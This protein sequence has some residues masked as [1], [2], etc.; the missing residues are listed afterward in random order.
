MTK[1]LVKNVTGPQ[2]P[3]G[4]AGAAGATGPQGPQGPAG[5]SFV[6]PRVF[7]PAD[8]GAVFDAKIATDVSV[9]ATQVIT[10]A[11]IAANAAVGMW[12]MINGAR[13]SGDTC[14]IGQITNISGGNITL[15]STPLPIS[16]S[17]TALRAVYGTDDT[18]GI[19][20]A[21]AAAKTYG[22][23]H[24]M[25][26]VVDIGDRK[27]IVATNNQSDDGTALYNTSVKI[28]FPSANNSSK[29][30][31]VLRGIVRTDHLEYWNATRTSQIGGTIYALLTAPST[32]DAT[33]GPQSVIGA[34]VPSSS[35]GMNGVISPTFVNI[36]PIVENLMIVLPTYSNLTAFDFRY[37]TGLYMDGCSVRAFSDPLEGTGTHLTD[38]F[39]DPI[40]GSRLG[41]GLRI[42]VGGNNADVYIPSFATEGV[43]M[44]LRTP[45]EHIRINRLICIYTA[46]ILGIDQ[47]ATS[48]GLSIG[49][50]TAEA[51]QGGIRVL[52][53]G[54]GATFLNIESWSTENSASVS[55]G[56]GYDIYDPGN[57]LHGQ[58]FFYDNTDAR[59]PILS[60]DAKNFRVI[61]A[62]KLPWNGEAQTPVLVT[63][64]DG[65]TINTNAAQGN[66]FRVTLGGNRTMAAPTNPADGQ[67]I[68]YEIVQDGTGSRTLTWDAAFSFGGGVAPVLTTTAGG[69]DLVGFRYSS[70]KSKWLSLGFSTGF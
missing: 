54:S 31:P 36:K 46:V 17:A 13:G 69:V 41:V 56:G 64:T 10:S 16:V 40:F 9:N 3:A 70:T 28:P 8:Y 6:D 15:G 37:A 4:A 1:I 62:R 48:H 18:T 55:G 52:D 67:T 66:E 34:P 44:A 57:A 12:V 26:C 5:S 43:T 27:C 61:N 24:G 50:V 29:F 39:N 11:T 68:T 22:E 38:E 53:G 63:L 25:S 7:D 58:M 47:S 30:I 20:A 42:P 2:G 19:N 32:L 51:Y 21:W 33:Y 35:G 59:D 14:A 45:S 60:G 65:A 23:A 49:H